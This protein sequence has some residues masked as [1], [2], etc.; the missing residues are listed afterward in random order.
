MPPPPGSIQDISDRL[1]ETFRRSVELHG[2]S[3]KGR[4]RPSAKEIEAASAEAMQRF[5]AAAREERARHRLGLIGRARVAFGVQQRLL[6][7]GYP[8]PLVKQVLFAMLV[9]A[10]TGDKP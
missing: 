10:F 4:R 1:A 3:A 5:L 2:D 9:S 6:A 7:V 8:A